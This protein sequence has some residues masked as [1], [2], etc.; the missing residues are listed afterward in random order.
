V[1]S[2]LGKK[3]LQSNTRLKKEKVESANFPPS[4]PKRG[5]KINT[6]LSKPLHPQ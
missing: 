3:I 1:R 6:S 4:N 2:A 5:Q